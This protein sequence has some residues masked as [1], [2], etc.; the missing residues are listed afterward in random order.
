[1]APRRFPNG[2]DRRASA[3]SRVSSKSIT[4]ACDLIRARHGLAH[5]I[6]AGRR[7]DHMN[8]GSR[9]GRCRK[10]QQQFY[11]FTN[12]SD[13]TTMAVVRFDPRIR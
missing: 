10:R 13:A 6:R 8:A 5:G 9:S 12:V 4:Q 11:F 1:M 7:R 2:V 3:C